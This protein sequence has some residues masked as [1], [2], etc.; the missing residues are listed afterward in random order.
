M[1]SLHNK[2]VRRLNTCFLE[3]VDQDPISNIDLFVSQY[4]PN[5]IRLALPG[6]LL[7]SSEIFTG[8]SIWEAQTVLAV[9][10]DFDSIGICTYLHQ[11]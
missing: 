7:L 11:M 4:V 10:M 3:F 2:F 1:P 9:K 8:H 5:K 6:V